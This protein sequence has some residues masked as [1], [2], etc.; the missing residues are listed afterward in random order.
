MRPKAGKET[1]SELSTTGRWAYSY[2]RVSTPGQVDRD[3]LD[4]QAAAFEP[5]CQK[6]GLTPAP[7]TL[8]DRGRSAYKGKHHGRHGALGRWLQQARDGLV[9]PGSVL[10]IEELSRFSREAPTDA[11]RLL[12]NEVFAQGLAL[13]VTQFDSVIGEAE[14]N[15]NAG[16][17]IRLQLAIQLAHDESARKG[18]HSRRNWQRRHAEALA[19]KKDPSARCRPWWLDWDDAS[20][21]FIVIPAAAAM[22]QRVFELHGEGYGQNRVARLMN[23]EGFRGSQGQLITPIVIAILLRDRRV[24]GERTMKGPAGQPHVIPGYFPPLVPVATFERCGRLMAARDTAP[25]RHGKGEH[26]K[27][28][29]QGVLSCPCGRLLT[30]SSSTSR[31]R[32]YEYLRCR[33]RVDGSCPYGDDPLIPYDEE[34]LLR[35]FMDAKWEKYFHRPRANKQLQEARNDAAAADANLARLQQ[36]EENAKAA[37]GR[38]LT[39]GTL[40]AATANM[41]GRQVQEATART[42]GAEAVATAA[43][44]KQQRLEAQPSGKEAS[45]AIREKAAAFMATDR[46][47]TAERRRFNS[48]LGT[49]GVMIELLGTKRPTLWVESGDHAIQIDEMLDFGDGRPCHWEWQRVDGEWGMQEDLYSMG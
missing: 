31:G 49:L 14:F 24:I 38:L 26:V 23:A 48:W 2:S 33:G 35:L 13:G 45:R 16:D 28:L 40:D 22:V 20:R 30:L 6:H 19:G 37:M 44:A 4:R 42:G 10:V 17:A 36:E 43:R 8:Q 11:L 7:D 29:F 5:F 41:L 39:A 34:Y 21:D 47:N 25:G 3:G 18:V 15:G 12:L 46:H 32:K 1:I 9:Q 27:N